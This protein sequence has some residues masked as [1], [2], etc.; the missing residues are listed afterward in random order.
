MFLPLN[1]V[2]LVSSGDTSVRREDLYIYSTE[3]VSLMARYR[4]FK[5]SKAFLGFNI[6]VL[7]VLLKTYAQYCVH[8]IY[9]CV[10]SF[11][12][13]MLIPL[14]NR[15]FVPFTYGARVG[16]VLFHILGFRNHENRVMLG[17][18]LP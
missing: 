6:E 2:D 5:G 7:K 16:H 12:G 8:S 17:C 18:S 15:S 13:A 9:I 11:R 1:D 3:R 4:I 14:M 10:C